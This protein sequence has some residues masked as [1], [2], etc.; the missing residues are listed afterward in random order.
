MILFLFSLYLDCRWVGFFPEKASCSRRTELK[1]EAPLRRRE[2]LKLIL[3]SGLLLTGS[4]CT[5]DAFTDQIEDYGETFGVLNDLTKCIG[6]RK[7]EWACNDANKLPVQTIKTFED[8]S[9]FQ[10]LRRP[11]SKCFTVVNHLPHIYGEH[12]VGGTSWMFLSSKPFEGIGFPKLP[13]TPPPVLTES[14]QHAIFQHFL[15]EIGLASVLGIASHLTNPA[16]EIPIVPPGKT[17]LE[18]SEPERQNS[19]VRNVFFPLSA[20]KR[21]AP[22]A[23]HLL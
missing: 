9:V 20:K 15:P 13:N 10:E 2:F 22:N 4:H 7:C 11:D 3:A 6:C 8:K 14:I 18:L 5:A 1:E 23:D 19:C 17:I 12:E 21:I 16:N